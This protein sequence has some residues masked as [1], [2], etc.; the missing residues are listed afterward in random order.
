[1]NFSKAVEK[2]YPH[3]RNRLFPVY[4]REGEVFRDAGINHCGLAHLTGEYRRER[5]N[6]NLHLIVISISG[7]G[8]FLDKEGEVSVSKGETLFFPARVPHLYGMKDGE[9]EFIF[10]FLEPGVR[11]VNLPNRTM[12]SRGLAPGEFD[13]LMNLFWSE[14][15]KERKDSQAL[16]DHLAHMILIYLQREIEC[17]TPD[18]EKIP[19]PV[20]QKELWKKVEANIERRWTVHELA[21]LACMS[22]SSFNRLCKKNYGMQPMKIVGKLRINRAKALL[23]M[24]DLSIKQVAYLSGYTNQLSFSTS[25][26]K[27]AGVTP[28]EFRKR[29]V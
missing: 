21:E 20:E 24:S 26:R 18:G 11:I 3:G 14:C 8:Y 9:W 28:T 19:L 5:R 15:L 12:V 22:V 13:T 2:N 7:S 6:H 1:M 4:G 10:F 25:F 16:L 27:A 17:F 23:S 29:Y